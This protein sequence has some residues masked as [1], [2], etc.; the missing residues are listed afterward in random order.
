MQL[1]GVFLCHQLNFNVF[2]LSL[3]WLAIDGQIKVFRLFRHWEL[4]HYRE[5]NW[6]ESHKI[7]VLLNIWAKVIII[8]EERKRFKAQLILL[9]IKVIFFSNS[10]I[11]SRFN[12]LNSQ[13]LTFSPALNLISFLH[14]LQESNNF[15]LFLSAYTFA[16][17]SILL[18]N[19]LISK[20]I[21]ITPFKSTLP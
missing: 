12:S 19:Q 5:L 17:S 9:N 11:F 6:F 4:N 1:A 14:F 2:Y 10:I 16:H 20:K 13:Y 18:L 15:A 8:L 7:V 21:T 3:N